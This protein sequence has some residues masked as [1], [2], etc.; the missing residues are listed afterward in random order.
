MG[1]VGLGNEKQFIRAPTPIRRNYHR[2][3]RLE[4]DTLVVHTLGIDGGAEDAATLEA[5]E[6]ALFFEYLA[7]N[8]GQSENL[9]VWVRQ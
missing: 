9:A 1:I 7:R 6:G 8:E 5:F 2:V 3:F 4:H